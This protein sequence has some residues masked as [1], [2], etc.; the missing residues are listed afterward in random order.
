MY[1]VKQ[2]DRNS[3]VSLGVVTAC[4]LVA[5]VLV[6]PSSGY[7]ALATIPIDECELKRSVSNS[8]NGFNL[9]GSAD[10]MRAVLGEPEAESIAKSPGNKYPHREYRYE[11]LRIVF[12]THG[13]STL[14][15]SF[16]VSS[17][18]YRLGSGVGV[19]STRQEIESTLGSARNLRS[20]DFKYMVYK[21][22]GPDGRP[23]GAY[24]K[25]RLDREVAV[26]FSVVTL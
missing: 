23:V 12:S 25:F 22:T 15:L 21:V 13:W 4:L 8:I 10:Q 11:G 2:R 9:G 16:F 17:D 7:T 18:K 19:G 3:Q 20:G 24:L 14:A 1:A 26:E 6:L 5:V